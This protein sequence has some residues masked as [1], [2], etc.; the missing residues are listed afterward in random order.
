[1]AQGAGCGIE[2]HEKSY[3]F[4]TIQNNLFGADEAPI[5]T[6]FKGDLVAQAK[7]SAANPVQRE[8]ARLLSSIESLGTDL[9]TLEQLHSQYRAKFGQS[10]PQR[11]A[12]Q[13]SLQRQMVVFLHERLQR[14][15]ANKA[16]ALTASNRKAIARIIVSFSMNFA[17]QGD[18]QMRAIHDQYSDEK[19]E[20]QDEAQLEDMREL[21]S[22]M[23]IELPE[24]DDKANALE[25]AQAAL[26]ALQEKIQKEQELEEQR[27]AKRDEKREARRAEKA[28]TDPKAQAKL[29]NQEQAAQE[30]QS[31]LKNIYRQLARQLHP[32]RAT[33]DDERTLNHDLMSQVNAAYDKQDLLTLL[34]L[35]LKASQ[36]DASAMNSVAEEKLKAWVSLLRAQAKELNADVMNLRMQMM[37]EFRLPYG[38]PVSAQALEASFARGMLEY[39]EVLHLMR[40]DLALIEDD[41]GLKRWAKAQSRLIADDEQ[42]MMAQD[43]DMAM[44]DDILNEIVM[45]KAPRR[46]AKKKR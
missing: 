12:E 7:A 30:A 25:Q 42:M 4:M 14:P 46:P 21:L 39:D 36:I 18:A 15:E 19:M 37:G 10:L 41:A 29:A 35:Q 44:M 43:E 32:D 6:E 2:I 8:F 22:Q 9:Q 5:P 40:S 45:Q 17:M 23:G 27:Q 34:K 28:K 24:L 11:K 31:S 3:G 38:Q 20:T 13:E 1:L 16:K 26:K 33:S